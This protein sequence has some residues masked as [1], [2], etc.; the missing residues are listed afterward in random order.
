MPF[1]S[2]YQQHQS[3]EFSAYKVLT[4]GCCRLG[5]TVSA[6]DISAQYMRLMMQ[7]SRAVRVQPRRA[8]VLFLTVTTDL[9]EYIEK[10]IVY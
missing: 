7:V 4:C 10:A 5:A 6:L 3:T 9:I 1:L 2:P 8:S